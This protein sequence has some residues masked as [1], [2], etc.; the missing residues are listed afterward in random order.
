MLLMSISSTDIDPFSGEYKP[1]INFKRVLFPHPLFPT[2]ATL[3][4]A[5]I[6]KETSFITYGLKLM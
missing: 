6:E 4:P 2:I 1:K 3:S 5:L